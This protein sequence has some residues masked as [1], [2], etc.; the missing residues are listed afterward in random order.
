MVLRGETKVE[1]CGEDISAGLIISMV[2]NPVFKVTRLV[3]LIAF[4][5]C[6]TDS[7]FM[8][9]QT[10]IID[11]EQTLNDKNRM[12]CAECSSNQYCYKAYV[13]FSTINSDF[14]ITCL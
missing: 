9:G 10:W 12:Q 7:Q 13:K 8:H 5:V 14:G 11:I 1:I 4:R 2:S 6:R 3:E